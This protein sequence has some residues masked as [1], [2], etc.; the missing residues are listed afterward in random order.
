ML[1]SQMKWNFTY[2]E[3]DRKDQ[4]DSEVNIVKQLLKNRGITGTKETNQFLN[5]QLTDLHQLHLLNG[6]V[7]SKQRIDQAIEQ[8]ES[9]LVF[10]DY[11]AD[12]VTATT[13]L[14]ETLNE[15]GA[16]CD[17]YIPNRFAE[18][19]GP[20]PETFKQAK[21]QGF[22]VIITVDTG[23][24]AIESAIVAKDLGIDLIITDHH[25]S[26][27]VLPEAYAIIHPKLSNEY[28]FKELAG[29]G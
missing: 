23:I 9:I 17:Y 26:S 18:G 2:M 6:L 24:A 14:V 29:V 21:H 12:G 10:G 20:N 27:D 19:Y 3:D 13:I 4:V 7:E 1:A 25:E 5:P 28:P 22:D 11:D 15:L 16:M 8:G